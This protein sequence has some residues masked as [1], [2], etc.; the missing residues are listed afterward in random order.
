MEYL[1]VILDGMDQ[2]KTNLP[3]LQAWGS[4]NGLSQEG[5]LHTHVTGAIVHGRNNMFIIDYQ[6]W[7]QDS[8]LI[9]NVLFGSA[10]ESFCQRCTSS[11]IVPAVG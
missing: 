7:P 3:H 11:N 1:S 10:C 9:L 2:R 4:F 8:N 6:Q 5:Y